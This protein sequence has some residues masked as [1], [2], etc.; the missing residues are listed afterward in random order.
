MKCNRAAPECLPKP[1]KRR[2]ACKDCTCGLAQKLQAEDTQRLAKANT[3]LASL[4]QTKNP[5]PP[6]SSS[7]SSATPI[8]K[9]STTDLNDADLELDF[10]VE[11]KVG[12]C[13]NCALGDAFR[14]EG[15]PDVGLPAFKI[16]ESVR[17]GVGDEGGV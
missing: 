1:G 17:L 9:L 4:H 6:S 8:P 11:G 12:S 3:D 5:L 14:C 15:C 7:S 16:G 2:R 13:G 10:T